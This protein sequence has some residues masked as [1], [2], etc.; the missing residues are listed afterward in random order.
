MTLL[1]DPGEA[2]GLCRATTDAVVL[3]RRAV[4]TKV[5]RPCY[6]AGDAF[7]APALGWGSG[8]R[9]TE[10]RAPG[11]L[12]RRSRGVTVGLRVAMLAPI[13][14]RVPP[15]HYGPWE[16]FASLLT[17]GLVER[18]VDV[19][20]FASGDS[21]TAGR[22]SSVVP[23]GWEED[24]DAN[25]KVSE[26]LHISALF[27]RA[28][29]FDLIHNSFDF[30]PLTYS[31][32]V[33]TPVLTT[34]HGFS[35][36]AIVA[37]YEKYD[38]LGAYIAIS[39]ADRHPRLTYLATIHHGIDTDGFELHDSPDGYLLFFG[40]IHPD[41]GAAD[42]IDVAR[43]AGLPLVIAG[44]IQ[45]QQYYDEVVAPS[46]DGV[47]VRYVGAVGPELRTAVLGGAIALLHLI[48]FEEPFG[49]SVV[50]AMACGTPVVAYRRGSMPEL[51]ADGVTG[52]LVRDVEH[53]VE[54]V[55]GA[56]A[57]DR[58]RVRRHAV[59]HFGVDRMTDDYLAAYEA[60][61]D[62]DGRRVQQRGLDDVTP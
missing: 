18:G 41:K 2:S 21:R 5:A 12:R 33:S 1:A 46:I 24:P 58:A 48:G 55:A 25:P 7:V 37:V 10:R 4:P 9:S 50:E 53:A 32:L 14:W 49:Y 44:I 61:V 45:D 15:R 11:A 40:R 42:A 16:Q 23:R 20:L 38:H 43:R 6:L 62:G 60:L 17:E 8:L 34:I 22:L 36:P 26:C 3:R 30:L 57:L 35:S 56:R 27:E 52:F 29:E 13:A 19:T 59:A 31:A 47:R 51:I 54:A 28:G 39:D